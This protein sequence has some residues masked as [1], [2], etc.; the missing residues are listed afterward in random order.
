[1]NVGEVTAGF[2][3]DMKSVDTAF[4]GLRSHFSS[5]ATALS[6]LGLTA[7][8]T[9]PLLRAA[10]EITQTGSAFEAQMSRVGA[11]M[12]LEGLGM[13]AEEARRSLES[14]RETALSMGEMTSLSASEAAQAMESLAMAGW[15][16]GDIEKAIG[17]LIRLAEV[18]GS[19]SLQDAASIVAD[20]LTSLQLGS[21][22]AAHLADVL[23]AAATS[24]N[25]DLTK[26]GMTFKY[27]ANMAGNLGFSMED[28]ALASGLMANAG[29]KAQKAG[30]GLRAFLN[31]MSSSKKAKAALQELGIS[32]YDSEGRAYS[33]R[34]VIEDLRSAMSGLSQEER[35]ATAYALAGTGGMNAV[36][37]LVGATEESFRD[38][39]A[40]IDTS[41]SAAERA[42]HAMLDNLRGEYVLLQ[43]A[44]D[45]SKIQLLG[46]MEPVLR[47]LVRAG[48]DLVRTFNAFDDSQ[49]GAVLKL[50]GIAAAAGPALTALS[51]LG[52]A[53][54]ALGTGLM[55]MT[56]PAGLFMTG[57]AGIS[58]A[59]LSANGDMAA[60][61][62][63]FSAKLPQLAQKAQTWLFDMKEKV[64]RELP[65]IL[66]GMGLVLQ[67]GISGLMDISSSLLQ[68]LPD[69]IGQALPKLQDMVGKVMDALVSGIE[70]N[71]QTLPDITGMLAGLESTALAMI[72]RMTEAGLQIA[73]AFLES[74]QNLPVQEILNSLLASL[75]SVLNNATQ[76]MSEMVPGI[77]RALGQALG[78][79]I[80]AIP[81]LDWAG[82]GDALKQAMAGLMSTL[83]E[84]FSSLIQGLQSALQSGMEGLDFTDAA[85]HFADRLKYAMQKALQGFS[86]LLQDMDLSGFSGYVQDVLTRTGKILTGGLQALAETIQGLDM[87]TVLSGIWSGLDPSSVLK[88]FSDMLSGMLPG[89]MSL[90][91]AAVGTL[92][93]SLLSMLHG[94]FTWDLEN[95]GSSVAELAVHIVDS[96][97]QTLADLDMSR[98]I[99][100]IL[101]GI[102]T[103]V[104]GLSRVGSGILDTLLSELASPESIA[105]FR[106]TGFALIRQLAEG[107][108]SGAGALASSLVSAVGNILTPVMK[109]LTGRNIE[110]RTGE[111]TL[112]RN[113]WIR[114]DPAFFDQAEMT[115]REIEEKLAQLLSLGGIQSGRDLEMLKSLRSSMEEA[116]YGAMAGLEMGMSR[117]DRSGMTDLLGQVLSDLE[118]G[119]VEDAGKKAAL[120]YMAGFQQ[121]IQGLYLAD[122]GGI[123]QEWVQH[124]AGE[125][126]DLNGYVDLESAARELGLELQSVLGVEIPRGYRLAFNGMAAELQEITDQ[127]FR[128]VAEGMDLEGILASDLVWEEAIQKTLGS[129][130]QMAPQLAAELE[131]LGMNAMD[132][133]GLE[134]GDGL[135]E[136][137][138][139]ALNVG[140]IQGAGSMISASLGLDSLGEAVSTGMKEAED[141]FAQGVADL[142]SAADPGKD[143]TE[144]FQSAGTEAVMAATSALESGTESILAASQTVS[145]AAVEAFARTMSREEGANLAAAFLQGMDT[146]LKSAGQACAQTAKNLAQT[147]RNALTSVLT[148]SAGR[149]AGEQYMQGLA[150]GIKSGAQAAIQAARAAASSITSSTK[151]VLKIHSPSRVALDM[152]R[153]Y[154]EGL[155]QGL[156]MDAHGLEK[157]VDALSGSLRK[158]PDIQLDREMT[159]LE[160]SISGIRAEGEEQQNESLL[161]GMQGMVREVHAMVSAVSQLSLQMDGE[162]VGRLVSPAVSRELYREAQI[163]GR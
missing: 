112:F 9:R 63:S 16:S 72:P 86:S 128:T 33:L 154:T 60:L 3:L 102:G 53:V 153:M 7:L 28:L 10:R 75:T 141:A 57:L 130:G 135:K 123:L 40:A 78:K 27:V 26:L 67:S 144:L 92:G 111:I 45:T 87:T 31:N 64:Q 117:Y 34:K 68:T 79:V 162:L 104:E 14:L 23:T 30:T 19:G 49:R 25:T 61:L 129:F 161:S 140:D 122:Q 103:A 163:A 62:E 71:L 159:T 32:L 69:L 114:V 47:S 80:A 24:S 59:A 143:M 110:N 108:L 107:L 119:S 22:E 12:N 36:L 126:L 50:A 95:I 44:L 2:A 66:D 35:T 11:V 142:T 147:I 58:M 4:H 121:E 1:M 46:S 115:G 55:A 116:G 56:G 109:M 160:E 52:P 41:Q 146:A 134:L 136:S 127:G 88:G 93:E 94:M 152:G 137:I 37:A 132:V 139:S 70:K 17:P 138:Q 97:T 98:V 106:E 39:A 5:L 81:Q 54:S 76:Q 65:G 90:L 43:S 113:A 148:S 133:L 150:G 96:L 82:L 124:F 84:A 145:S 99:Q 18:A 105:R 149:Q 77:T 20:T 85:G 120:L 101:S 21:G 38:L 100:G 15:K 6:G 118:Q 125:N 158:G 29:I 73:Q 74:V 155:R 13:S 157:A 51:A 48:T 42:S 156:L 91:Q 8:V 89:L 83:P 151:S 131:K